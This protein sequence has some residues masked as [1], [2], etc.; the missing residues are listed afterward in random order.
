[1]KTPQSHP[2]TKRFALVS[3]LLLASVASVA[4]AQHKSPFYAGFGVG[5]SLTD[6]DYSNQVLN[7]KPLVDPLFFK[8]NSASINNGARFGGHLYAGYQFT[9]QLAVELGYTDFG[10]R[11][12]KYEVFASTYNANVTGEFKTSG[13]SLDLVGQLPV[14][15]TISVNGRLGV[16]QTSLRYRDSDGFN[17]PSTRQSRLH[18][19]VGAAWQFAPNMAATLDYQ[20][21]NDVGRDFAWTTTDTKAN[22]SLNYNL[23]TAGLRFNF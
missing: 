22:G 8:V 1:M 3:G 15:P 2:L 19:G 23:V 11:R 7:A 5:G 10:S 21:V 4:S 6:G 13:V 14:S 17:A 12:S 16:M 18:V 9:P 20:R